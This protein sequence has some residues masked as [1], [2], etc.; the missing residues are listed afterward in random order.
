MLPSHHYCLCCTLSP[1]TIRH[2]LSSS[3]RESGLGQG[4]NEFISWGRLK[5]DET[6][7]VFYS[8]HVG[9][10]YFRKE[11]L[12]LRAIG[13]VTFPEWLKWATDQSSH[14]LPQPAG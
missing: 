4:R 12:Y 10:D 11:G 6:R 8:F 9:A 1:K 14:Q 2:P 7:L 13:K 5:A 3:S